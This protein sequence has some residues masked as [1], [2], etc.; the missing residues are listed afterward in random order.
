MISESKKNINKIYLLGVI[1]YLYRAERTMVIRQ[2]FKY[3]LRYS[4]TFAS[5]VTTDFT[6]TN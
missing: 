2:G 4:M 3:V 6:K 1:K 5:N